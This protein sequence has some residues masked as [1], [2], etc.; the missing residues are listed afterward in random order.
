MANTLKKISTVTV[1]SGGAVNIEFTNIPQTYTDLKL[2]VSA[3][4]TQTF[5]NSGNF[6]TV[7]PNGLN[8]NLSGKYLI[9]IGTSVATG[10]YQPFGYMSASD[11]T[12][13]VF[14]SGEHYIPNYTSANYKSFSSDDTAESNASIMYATDISAG[15]WSSTSAITSLTL[16]PG[17]GNFAQYTTATLYGIS[18]ANTTAGGS[19]KATG[20]NQVYTDGTYWYHVFTSDGNFV[21]STSM[22]VDYLV[23]AGG[24]GGGSRRGAGG[25]AGKSQELTAQSLTAQAYTVTVGGG[26]AGGAAGSANTGANGNDSVFNSTTSLKGNGGGADGAAGGTSG[27]SFAGG[28]SGGAPNYGGGGGGGNSAVGANGTTTAGG[29]GGAGTASTITGSSISRAGGGGG[30]TYDG[31]TAGAGTAGGGN[32]GSGANPGTAGSNGTANYGGGGGGGGH[33]SPTSGQAGGNGGSGIVI[34][35]YAA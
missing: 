11:Y 33:Y 31:G 8:T 13:S 23:V 12:A 2:V 35:R 25:G 10:S 22:N 17:G 24:G 19:G 6:Y 32:G 4:G 18:N 27:N 16:V 5:A 3:R 21:P 7:R 29:A 28:S 20:G 30:G 34:V 14:G 15:L 9:S 1:G 26:G